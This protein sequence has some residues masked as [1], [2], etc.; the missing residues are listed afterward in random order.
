MSR[1]IAF[2]MADAKEAFDHMR[3][4]HEDVIEYGGYAYGHNLFT[5]DTGNRTLRRCRKCGGYIL[6][7]DSEYHGME[8][9]DYYTDYFPVDSPEEADELN[10]K[11]SGFEIETEFPGRYLMFDKGVHWSK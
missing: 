6:V 10:K 3:E 9:D 4:D 11:Y 5:W 7:Q 2:N 8:D 1:C